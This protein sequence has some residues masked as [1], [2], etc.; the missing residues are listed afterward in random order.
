[1][2]KVIFQP[3]YKAHVT[4]YTVRD[5]SD[6]RIVIGSLELNSENIYEFRTAGGMLPADMLQEVV[7]KLNELNVS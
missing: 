2:P 4:L 6:D 5:A 1:M 7:D 3:H